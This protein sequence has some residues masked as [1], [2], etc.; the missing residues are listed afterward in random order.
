[1]D[2]TELPEPAPTDAPRTPP[3]RF[4]P[5]PLLPPLGDYLREIIRLGI[6]SIR[7]AMPAL[8]LLFCYRF[9]MG[10]YLIFANRATS[11]MGYPDTGLHMAGVLVVAA[12]Y[13]PLL[14]LVYTPFLPLQDALLKGE[15]RS[16]F[17]CA[18]EVLELL[19]RFSLSGIAQIA[20]VA[21]PAVFLVIGAA[22]AAAPFA[23][24]P[25]EIKALF[26]LAAM[27]P[28]M[29]WVLFAMF[30]LSFA[31]PLLLLDGRGP[32]ESV[33][34]SVRL[35]RAQFGGLFGRL[36]LFG[37]LLFVVLIVASFPVSMLAAVSAVAGQQFLGARIAGLV[38]TAALSA[39]VFPFTV[40]A[41]LV[42][43]RAVVAAPASAP[44]A[45]GPDDETT[46]DAAAVTGSH[47]FE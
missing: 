32:I 10:L 44:A 1:M 8:V 18:K 5:P 40:S 47:P 12:A 30:L 2:A 41:L 42:L 25:P 31:A 14:V 28:A 23:A 33:R 35:V 4:V 16:F 6:E 20:L 11:P 34:E 3:A 15:R 21:G 24:A 13:L 45:P 46:D 9:G 36:L 29:L 37:V 27:I 26:V 19:P 17:D 43:Y 38:W 39:A 22:I 7:P